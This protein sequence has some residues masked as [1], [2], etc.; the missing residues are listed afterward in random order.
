MLLGAVWH[1]RRHTQG[2]RRVA[3]RVA[4][5][6]ALLV[7]G[8][9]VCDGP[10]IVRNVKV[11]GV[12]EPTAPA[13]VWSPWQYPAI[14]YRRWLRTWVNEPKYVGPFEFNQDR[15]RFSIEQLPPSAFDSPQERQLVTELF[16]RYNDG[17]P[18]RGASRRDSA[19]APVGLT[20]DL[21]A[22][23]ETVARDRIR[24]HPVRYY[25][26]L[27]AERVFWMWASPHS[28]YYPFEGDLFPLADLDRDTGQQIWLPMF[29]LLTLAWSV[30]GVAGAMRLTSEPASGFGLVLLAMLVV[31]RLVALGV[32]ENPEPRYMVELFP[33]LSALGGVALASAGLPARWHLRAPSRLTGTR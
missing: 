23:F 31:P 19:S 12:F 17:E 28:E 6:G 8:F 5:S 32:M 26:S 25:V 18:G 29:A 24:R 3:T 22:Q 2:S 16:S 27:P 30:F 4:H 9:L 15:A 1:W 13:R 10:W 20:A 7:L 33:F 11:F 14:G 21:D